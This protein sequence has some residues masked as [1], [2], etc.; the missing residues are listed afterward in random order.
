MLKQTCKRL[1]L[2]LITLAFMLSLAP[3]IPQ[4]NAADP[5][6]ECDGNGRIT[7]PCYYCDGSGSESGTNRVCGTC[8]GSGWYYAQKT[9]ACY[10]CSGRG[11]FYLPYANNGQG[12]YVTCTRCSGAGRITIDY[13]YGTCQSCNGIGYIIIETSKKCTVCEGTGTVSRN[14]SYCGG[15]GTKS[16]NTNRTGPQIRFASTAGFTLTLEEGYAATSSG[17]FVTIVEDGVRLTPTV[18]KTSG[19]ALIVLNSRTRRLDIGE[20]LTAGIYP[21]E[22][23]A[24]NGV[25]PDGVVIFTLTIVARAALHISGTTALTI[26]AGYKTAM[27]TDVFTISG[28]PTPTVTK[29]SGNP[30]ITWN[31]TTKKIDI[32][33]GLAAGTYPVVLTASNGVNQNTT[34]TFILTVMEELGISGLPGMKLSKGY[35]ATATDAFSITGTPTPT[36]TKTSGNA[37]ITWNNTTKRLD[38]AAGLADGTY[39]VVLTVSNGSDPDVKFTFTLTVT[40]ELGISGTTSMTLNAGYKA[41]STDV[42][43]ISGSPSPT[44]TKTSGNASVT[45]NNTTKKLDI[46]AG[47]PAGT[48]PVVL[49]ASNGVNPDVTFAFTLTVK[50]SQ[51]SNFARQRLVIRAG[52]FTDVDENAWYGF[53]NQKVIA[54]AYEYGLMKGNGDTTF[55]P[56]GNVTIAEAITIA[57]RVH[58]IYTTGAEDFVQSNPWYQVYIDYAVANGIIFTNSFN[59]YSRAA[60]RAEMAYIFSRSLPQTEFEERN[61]VNSLPDVNNTVPYSSA[62]ITLYKAGV[63]TGSDEKGTFHPYGN[64]TRAEAAAIIT[65]VIL[66]DMRA[67]GKTY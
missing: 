28:S 24:S 66:P 53:Y 65:R 27:S 63:L 34:F 5:C 16:N 17:A 41:T 67:S 19:N 57:A 13:D 18:T 64:I 20:G 31:N 47:L 45:W 1:L 33:A 61:T 50:N 49:T 39:P 21:V 36:V 37:A 2:C 12:A 11:Y 30:A 42:F 9:A 44:V 10:D 8:S 58:S 52:V 25:N 32:A 48:Y 38:I 26:N 55:N 4:A 35:A 54:S 29:T 3:M 51:M 43:V 56:T 60:T 14:C 23:T 62:V 59:D 15:T 6:A 40:E 7:N 22:L 46:A